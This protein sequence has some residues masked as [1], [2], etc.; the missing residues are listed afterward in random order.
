M[1]NENTVIKIM[2]ELLDVLNRNGVKADS[3]LSLEN[4]LQDHNASEALSTILTDNQCRFCETMNCDKCDSY[5][6]KPISERIARYSKLP[7]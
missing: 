1:K 2:A 6:K 3:E 5:S 7:K 4:F